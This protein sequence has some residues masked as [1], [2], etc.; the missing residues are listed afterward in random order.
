MTPQE[1]CYWLQGFFEIASESNA[2]VTLT[3]GQ[4]DMIQRHLNLVFTN[5]TKTK[6]SGKTKVESDLSPESIKELM[7][8]ISRD[9]ITPDVQ[10]TG[11]SYS[12]LAKYC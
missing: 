6:I 7:E 8:L 10:C 3:Q 5:V 1:F 4:V 12:P 9:R 11:V 2:K